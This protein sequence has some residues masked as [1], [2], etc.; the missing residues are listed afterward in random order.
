MTVLGRKLRALITSPHD[1][2]SAETEMI[3][4][5]SGSG[6]S[7]STCRCGLQR[8]NRIE[9]GQ[10]P[11]Q[12]SWGSYAQNMAEMREAVDQSWWGHWDQRS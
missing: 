7:I 1:H 4:A 10:V 11:W 8:L 3:E 2:R 12:S 5:S 6:W 9:L